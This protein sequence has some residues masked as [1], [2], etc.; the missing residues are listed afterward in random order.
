MLA[1]SSPWRHN[2]IFQAESPPSRPSLSKGEDTAANESRC[3]T[4][5]TRDVEVPGLYRA[6][7]RTAG[8]SPCKRVAVFLAAASSIQGDMNTLDWQ[9]LSGSRTLREPTLVLC[10]SARKN[11]G[12]GWALAKTERERVNGV[13]R[14]MGKAR[15]TPVSIRDG[16]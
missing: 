13:H 5:C 9:I 11:T 14:L 6:C 4:S 12:R 2:T 8:D 3:P 10:L 7:V 15:R 16:G 1:G